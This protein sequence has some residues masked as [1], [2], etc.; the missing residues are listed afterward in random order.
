MFT[1]IG[2][3][4]GYYIDGNMSET[5]ASNRKSLCNPLF[6]SIGLIA[7]VWSTLPEILQN[8]AGNEKRFSMGYTALGPRIWLELK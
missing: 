6:A 1:F 3:M 5:A 4:I 8:A 7:L 2:L